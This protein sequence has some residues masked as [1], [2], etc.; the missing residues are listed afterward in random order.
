MAGFWQPCFSLLLSFN[1]ISLGIDAG[2]DVFDV[3]FTRGRL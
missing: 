1:L 3:G 2:I